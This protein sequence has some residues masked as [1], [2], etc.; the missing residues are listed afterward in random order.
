MLPS[1]IP[2]VSNQNSG[3][4]DSC[5]GPRCSPCFQILVRAQAEFLD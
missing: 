3:L 2:F 5:H 1:V 4:L